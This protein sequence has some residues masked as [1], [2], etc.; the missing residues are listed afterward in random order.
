MSPSRCRP[1]AGNRAR[2]RRAGCRGGGRL[3]FVARFRRFPSSCRTRW[4]G[5]RGVLGGVHGEL[6]RLTGPRSRRNPCRPRQADRGA[7]MDA[8]S[9]DLDRLAQPADDMLGDVGD[10][11]ARA[12]AEREHHRELV[13]ADAGTERLGGN[14]RH[15]RVAD[16]AQHRVAGD[17]TIDVVDVLEAVEVDHQHCHLE[18]VAARV[19]DHLVAGLV[20]RRE[21]EQVG[22]LVARGEHFHRASA[23][24][25]RPRSERASCSGGRQQDQSDVEQQCGAGEAIGAAIGLDQRGDDVRHHP[26]ADAGEHEDGDSGDRR[27]KQVF[28]LS[29]RRDFFPA[30]A[31]CFSCT[32]VFVPFGPA[33]RRQS[34]TNGNSLTLDWSRTVI[35][36]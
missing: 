2:T 22:E 9:V 16:R 1:A 13:R 20:D 15:D 8:D 35:M 34:G 5:R 21:H 32:H 6:A 29:L 24:T 31:R 7:R 4:R 23:S 17:V 27:G 3:D 18:S 30:Q 10:D 12:L 36:R 14:G 19:L 28:T 33:P 25:R 11:L 26:H